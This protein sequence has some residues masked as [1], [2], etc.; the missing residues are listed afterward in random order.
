MRLS[1]PRSRPTTSRKICEH[2]ESNPDPWI[3]NQKLWPLDHRG[4]P[5]ETI[6]LNYFRRNYLSQRYTSLSHQTQVRLAVAGNSRTWELLVLTTSLREA[7]AHTR[8]R[9][10][11][12]WWRRRLSSCVYIWISQCTDERKL[13]ACDTLVTQRHINCWCWGLIASIWRT[14]RGQEILSSVHDHLR[15][16]RWTCATERNEIIAI[17]WTDPYNGTVDTARTDTGANS[18]Q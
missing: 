4:G 18:M 2:Q 5:S 15:L 10:D 9:A 11:I 12:S 13:A 14:R 1:G 6:R 8:M 3:C 7:T 17:G 16:K